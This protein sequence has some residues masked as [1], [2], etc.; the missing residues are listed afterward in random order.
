L[1]HYYYSLKLLV[2]RPS[3]HTNHSSVRLDIADNYRSRAGSYSLAYRDVWNDFAAYSKKTEFTYSHVASQYTLRSYVGAVINSTVVI[4]RGRS[5][6]N[7]EV[8][9]DGIGINDSTG[10]DRY[11]KP[12]FGAR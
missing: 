12:N 7:G 6:H 1:F 8:I 5:I 4:N 9:N 3:W 11:T 2:D 10:H